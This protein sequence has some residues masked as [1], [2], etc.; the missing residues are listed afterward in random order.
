MK[1]FLRILKYLGLG[2]GAFVVL[3]VLNYLLFALVMT[4]VSEGEPIGDRDPDRAGL[5]VLDI[6]EGPTG[7]RSANASF[8]DQAG[9]LIPLLNET[10]R[11]A[12][13]RGIPVVYV[14]SEVANPG[15]N[16]LNSTMAKG[17]EGAQLDERLEQ[18]AGPVLV[19][20]GNDSFRSGELDAWL[21]DWGVGRV[22]LTG[23]DASQC[24]MATAKGALN[25]GYRVD[26]L[27]D[28]VITSDAATLPDILEEYRALGI[29]GIDGL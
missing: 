4:R 29:T 6:Q 2:L 9:R 24:V 11:Y 15:I 1:T 16:F 14:R 19:K 21:E 25:R 10:I 17:S 5:L 28:A 18:G 7:E 3:L 22:I 27:T 23:L 13:E 20:H 12:V 26:V 8:Q